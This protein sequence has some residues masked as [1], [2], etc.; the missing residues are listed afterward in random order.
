MKLPPGEYQ[1]KYILDEN[2]WTH[3]ETQ[4]QYYHLRPSIS[5]VRI[6]ADRGQGA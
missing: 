4:V 1:Y 5:S 6:H 2:T 3:D